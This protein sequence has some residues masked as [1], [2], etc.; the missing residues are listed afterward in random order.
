LGDILPFVFPNNRGV[1]LVLGAY[2]DESERQEAQEP[3]CVGGYLFKPA[4]Y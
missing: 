3:I 1:V 4:A 2:F